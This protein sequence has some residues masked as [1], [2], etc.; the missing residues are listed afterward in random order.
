MRISA[1]L[2]A[3]S[4]LA[5][6]GCSTHT[7]SVS[8]PLASVD[9]SPAAMSAAQIVTLPV[10]GRDVLMSIYR[11]VTAPKGV[12]MLSHGAGGSPEMMRPLIDQLRRAGFAV[13]APLHRDSMEYAPAE[14]DDLQTAFGTRIADLQAASALAAQT[15]PGLPAGA[16][17]YS[18]G[19]LIALIGGGA[20]EGMVGARVPA[21]KAVATFSS[22]GMIPGLVTPQSLQT[23]AVPTLMVTGTADVVPGFIPDA[24]QH[25]QYFENAPIG[26]R[27]LVLVD[28]ATHDFVYGKETGYDAATDLATEFLTA[29]VLGNASALQ[30]LNGRTDAGPVKIRRR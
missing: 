5:L 6:L 15:F 18:Y 29:H 27:T 21:I 8:A 10:Q 14:R 28:G 13:V 12:L 1:F 24:A 19:S 20:L 11:P 25:V 26:N 9:Q 23:V 7:P 30:S 3:V 22:P 4:A 16:V 2:T 17:G